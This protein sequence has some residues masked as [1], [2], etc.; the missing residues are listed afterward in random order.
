MS[1]KFHLHFI[2]LSVQLNAIFHMRYKKLYRNHLSKRNDF[3]CAVL[4]FIF[5]LIYDE[6]CDGDREGKE[7]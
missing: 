2:L 1:F 5:E 3:V 4:S 7:R 6:F